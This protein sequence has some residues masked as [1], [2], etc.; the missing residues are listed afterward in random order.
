MPRMSYSFKKH[1]LVNLHFNAYYAVGNLIESDIQ[2]PLES[3]H[4]IY[5]YDDLNQLTE[6]TGHHPHTYVFDSL[7]NRLDK[8]GLP[9]QVNGI[10]QVKDDS[11]SSYTYD[12]SGNRLQKTSSLGSL[13]YTYDALNRLTEVSCEAW[14]STI[15]L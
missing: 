14:D 15:H 3:I 13:I 2:D 12:A 4:S 6:E 1:L 5:S 7:N 11:Q 10:N 8:D 9:Y